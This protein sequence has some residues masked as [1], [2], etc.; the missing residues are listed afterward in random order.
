MKSNFTVCA[1]VFLVA[2][3]AGGQTPPVPSTTPSEV[4]AISH[5]LRATF[6][7]Q[8]D[9]S[10]AAAIQVPSTFSMP[11]AQS[12]GPTVA[13]PDPIKMLE[14]FKDSDV[15][16]DVERMM[17]ILR[18]KRHEGWVLAAYPDPK[19]A[20][21]LIGAGFSLDLPERAHLQRDPLNPNPFIEPSS[22][23][24]WEAAGL[25]SARLD[26]ILTQFHERMDAWDKN[27]FRRQIWSLDP[28]ITNDDANALLRVGI[29]QAIYNARAYCR[30]FDRFSASQQMAVSQLV[31]QMGVNLEQFSTFLSLVNREN[32]TQPEGARLTKADVQYWRE[33]QLSLVQSQWARLYRD[34]A[35]AVIAMLDPK[36]VESPQGAERSIGRVLP[37]HRAH[38]RRAA[39]RQAGYTRRHGAAARRRAARAR[40]D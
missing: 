17:E 37:V 7:P 29:I 25:N 22:A 14:A 38:H 11:V 23:E 8:T 16:F 1:A 18:D 5:P 32:A 33:V 28:Q 19:T 13:S 27:G 15:K 6:S 34:R 12:G 31:Y 40:K 24:L 39:L 26:K 20:Q 10:A 2:V 3:S 9:P 21:P 4:P 30:N 36:Y 35:K